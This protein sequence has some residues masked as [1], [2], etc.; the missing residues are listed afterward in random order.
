MAL[1]NKNIGCEEKFKWPVQ[2]YEYSKKC[3]QPEVTKKPKYVKPN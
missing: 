3:S 2:M 1:S